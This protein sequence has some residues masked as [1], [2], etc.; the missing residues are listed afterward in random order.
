MYMRKLLNEKLLVT[1]AALVGITLLGLV[2]VKEL[3]ISYP[4]RVTTTQASDLSVVGEGKVE[5]VPDQASLEAGILVANAQTIEAAQSEINEK[6][7]A[8]VEALRKLGVEENDIKTSNYSVNPNQDYN[9]GVGGR[10]TGYNGNV[11][12]T[13]TIRNVENVSQISQ[14]VTTAGANQVYNVQYTVNNPEK[15]REEARNKAIE[16][17]KMQAEALADS[18][19]IR[20]GKVVNVVESSPNNGP[21]PMYDRALSVEGMGGANAPTM[22]PGTQEITSVVT[23]FFEKK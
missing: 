14:A 20:L 18:L 8:I 4:V 19:G 16:N 2:L 5:V 12:I 10:I 7:N 15:F 21:V 3:N 11:T 23:L 1:Y 6:N 13:V 9:P 17:A 22:Q